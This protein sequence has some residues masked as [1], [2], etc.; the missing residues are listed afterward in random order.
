MIWWL[1]T[2]IEVMVT[3]IVEKVEDVDAIDEWVC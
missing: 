2:Q 3:F 1:G